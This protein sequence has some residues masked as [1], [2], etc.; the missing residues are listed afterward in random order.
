MFERRL[1][2]VL[3]DALA[4]VSDRADV[5]DAFLA[6]LPLDATRGEVETVRSM[7]LD[8]ARSARPVIHGY[9]REDTDFPVWAIVLANEQETTRFLGDESDDDDAQG[10]PEKA[11][12]FQATYQV[13]VYTRHPDVTLYLYQLLRAILISRRQEMIRRAEGSL[14]VGSLSGAELSPDR[15]WLPAFLFVRAASLTTES[16]EYGLAGLGESD[17]DQ[18]LPVTRVT[19]LH[20]EDPRAPPDGLRHRVRTY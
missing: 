1:F 20:V 14:N 8:F 7:I 11:S 3:T 10:Q 2:Q 19:G 13:L 17:T 15:I 6:Q 9:A 5:L 16:V 12:V 4:R 18:P